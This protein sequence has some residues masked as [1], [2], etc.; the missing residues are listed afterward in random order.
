LRP[1]HGERLL[2]ANDNYPGSDRRWIARDK[3]DVEL[4]VVRVPALR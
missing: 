2:I 3:P 1:L 4:I